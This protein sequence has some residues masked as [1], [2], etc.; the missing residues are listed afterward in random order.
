MRATPR[1]CSTPRR[2]GIRFRP[3]ERHGA[4]LLAALP[5]ALPVCPTASSP[6]RVALTG[7]PALAG[8][9]ERQTLRQG[10][11]M[12]SDPTF[13]DHYLGRAADD[14]ALRSL[15]RSVAY[16]LPAARCRAPR[17]QVARLGGHGGERRV[18]QDAARLAGKGRL[19]G[20]PGLRHRCVATA[21]PAL[22]AQAVCVGRGRSLLRAVPERQHQRGAQQRDAA[23]R[24]ARPHA[25]R[26]LHGARPSSG[27]RIRGRPSSV[28]ACAITTTAPLSRRH[29]CAGTGTVCWSSVARQAFRPGIDASDALLET[30]RPGAS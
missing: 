4:F 5:L 16:L 8:Q 29:P 26:T 9:V 11:P 1:R 3:E 28:R 13:A 7:P 15:G 12:T 17:N 6:P 22:P 20:R 30:L 2:T 25:W 19:R 24:G 23:L 18:F 27:G 10:A 14:W 21:L